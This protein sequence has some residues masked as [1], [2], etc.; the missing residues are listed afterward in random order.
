[1]RPHRL[2]IEAF[3]P[4]AEAVAIGFD[5]LARDGLFLIHGPTGA[6]KT[7][8][9]D[10]LCFA[11]YGEVTGE[12][13]VKGLR[14]DHAPATAVPRVALEFT[15]AGERWRVERSPA[16]VLPRS[17]GGGTTSR[18]A[19]ASLVKL[20]GEQEEVMARAPAEVTREVSGLVGLDVARFRQVILL[21]QGR[22]AEV[23]RA[24]SEEREALLKTLF[25]TAL[26]ER[27][28]HWLEE[29]AKAARGAVF[30]G[31]RDLDS[32]LE[33][34]A[35]V[36]APWLASA[37]GDGA[38]DPADDGTADPPELPEL[39]RR[40]DAV[41]TACEAA[42]AAADESLE[43]GRRHQQTTARLAERWDRRAEGRRRAAERAQQ[44]PEVER[45]RA[46]LA[47]AERAE[48]LR[49][50][51]RADQEARAGLEALQRRVEE[52]LREAGRA[53]E[54][55]AA[56]PDAL[57]ALDLLRLPAAAPLARA[58]RELATRRGE[59]EE[60]ARLADEAGRVRAAAAVAAK[61]AA[62]AEDRVAKG[63][64]LLADSQAE[65]QAGEARLV[66]ARSAAD[67]LDGLQRA[68]AEARQRL[69]DLE[70]L[71]VA[72]GLESSA[73]AAAN[74]AERR[75]NE[76][77]AAVLDLR[78]RQ[79]AGMAARLAADLRPGEAC[80]VCG[81]TAH[82]RPARPCADAVAEP[83]IAAAEGERAAAEALARRAVAERA[84][85][86][87]E[88]LALEQR[89]A[90]AAT[91]PAAAR[92]VAT[93]AA[94]ALAQAAREAQERPALEQRLAELEGQVARYERR[95]TELREQATR[96]RQQADDGERRAG[97]LN[98]RV[99]ARL[100]EGVAPMA[101][102]ATF[103][104]LE[105][106]LE[107]LAGLAEEEG[108]AAS[109][110]AEAARRLQ[111]ELA[112]AGF[113]DAG[114]AA[115]ALREEAQ[116]QSWRERIRGFEEEGTR[117]AALLE[118]PELQ[119]LPEARPDTAA[120]EARLLAADADRTRALERRT[121]AR[122]AGEELRRLVERH[123]LGAVELT[124]RRE[125]SDRVGAVADRCQGRSHPNIS[126]QRWVLSAY[127]EE[128]CRH[129]NQRLELMT[130]GR[131]QLCLSDAELRKGVKAG[132]GLRVLDGY[133][134]EEREVSSLSGGETF[135]A[136]L[137]LALGVADTVQ[138]HSGGVALETLFIDEGFG[139]LDPD[140][141]QLAMDELDRL[142]QGGR[143]VG[144]ISHVGALRERIRQG[145]EVI[146]GERG[147]RV[148]T[149]PTALG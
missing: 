136:S 101:V 109:R 144:I 34:A 127:L 132:L 40:V 117:L 10:A 29:Q 67:R 1:M 92:A 19:K 103:P 59:L 42:L 98:T 14:S 81:A 143:M 70:Q 131:Y 44:A 11:L 146:A 8:L 57:V 50:S 48:G 89:A 68:A 30:D 79:V 147:S 82:P 62:D 86:E 73:A 137:A 21:P 83:Q 25:D 54:R 129:A 18:A 4:Y 27:A 17:R 46:A 90:D 112:T 91:D 15:A 69:V 108:R 61:E 53:R 128:I 13:S 124:Q 94:E 51:L 36:A 114:S 95:L 47:L 43:L 35:H 6:G 148:L 45:L 23:L 2:E 141:L 72:R 37:A 110:A 133:T 71:E 145:I 26:Y 149:G 106:A 12:R 56:L 88:R 39:L 52:R 93:A 80:P 119:E 55:A 85:L 96:Q 120:A 65:R 20:R 7:Y 49:G 32:L 84:R 116:R 122:S 138:A 24:R 104:P 31:Q 130:A 113:A 118:A 107:A 74:D 115:A 111:E 97:E 9:L 142:R 77:R 78:E 99:A 100:G 64:R 139:S 63:E 60:L 16:C 87:A 123:R 126:L 134:G 38:A 22:F 5:E 75:L 3:G 33:Q 135:Q 140:N 66:A 125:R 102:L 121:Q 105:A 41:A 28:A 58:A 76:A